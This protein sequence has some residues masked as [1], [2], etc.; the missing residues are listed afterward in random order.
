MPL[1]EYKCH[2]CGKTFEK[3]Q[4]FSDEPLKV[5]EDCGGQTERLISPPALQFKGTGW[6]IT[7]YGRSNGGDSK[8]GE[9]KSGESK[10]AESKTGES[11]PKADSSNS[12]SSDGKSISDKKSGGSATT[13]PASKSESK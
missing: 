5:H 6:Y 10:T 3:L 8:S 2:S 11:K 4:K 12:T 7:D 1:Y 9:S 13:A